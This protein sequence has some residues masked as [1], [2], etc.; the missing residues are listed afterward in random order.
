MRKTGDCK[1]TYLSQ[2]YYI[3]SNETQ[4]QTSTTH[5]TYQHQ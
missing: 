2:E 5:T 1:C 3:I 4:I